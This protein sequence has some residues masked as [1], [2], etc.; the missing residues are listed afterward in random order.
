MRTAKEPSVTTSPR[1]PSTRKRSVRNGKRNS[2]A[3]RSKERASNIG[4]TK[5]PT[6]T[7]R[8]NAHRASAKTV[9]KSSY[10]HTASIR[11]SAQG[12]ALLATTTPHGTHSK[13]SK[14][15]VPIATSHSSPTRPRKSTA[16]AI[17]SP[18]PTKPGTK[19]STPPTMQSLRQRVWWTE[20]TKKPPR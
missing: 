16:P 14:K 2:S 5:A 20:M 3:R 1:L 6:T 15:P 10:I 17:A 19:L 9:A 7:A 4:H 13:H 11:S 18:K 12:N 8:T